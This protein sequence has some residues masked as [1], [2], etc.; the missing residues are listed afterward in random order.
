M[1]TWFNNLRKLANVIGLVTLIVTSIGVF[2]GVNLF[3]NNQSVTVEN[4]CEFD[5]ITIKATSEDNSNQ[6]VNCN[7]NSK[8]IGITQ[9]QTK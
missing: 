4:G 5:D 3:S 7:N 8:I 1:K 9:K 6:N 2:A